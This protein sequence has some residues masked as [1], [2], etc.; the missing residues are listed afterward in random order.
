[1]A[2]YSGS[3]YAE[4]E[5]IVSTLLKSQGESAEWGGRLVS[6]EL[7]PHSGLGLLERSDEELRLESD[8]AISDVEEEVK[9]FSTELALLEARDS[10]VP[11]LSVR[12]VR[13]PVAL[14]CAMNLADLWKPSGDDSEEWVKPLSGVELD[15][16]LDAAR[17]PRPKFELISPTEAKQ[18]FSSLAADFLAVRLAAIKEV[19][20]NGP[21]RWRD[22]IMLRRRQT[23]GGPLVATPGANFTVT[24]NT[25]GLRVFWSGAYRIR[26]TYFNYPTTPTSNQLQAGRYVFGVDGLH[27]TSVQ[28][29][30]NAVVT[31]PGLPSVHLNY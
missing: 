10:Y 2:D 17:R 1:M 14:R 28:H 24:T 9:S 29:D 31:L 7:E 3:A 26:W 19:R 16:V 23:V 27:Y 11:A 18:T 15:E 20:Q 21:N 30:P 25:Y 22:L 5:K 13:V 6:H 4:A 12:D 8:V